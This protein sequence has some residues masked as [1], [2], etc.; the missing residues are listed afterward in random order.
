M[1]D[2]LTKIKQQCSRLEITE[3]HEIQKYLKERHEKLWAAKRAQEAIDHAERIKKLPM[4]T[5][6]I[7]K[8]GQRAGEFGKIHRI[9]RKYVG[10]TLECGDRWKFPVQMVDEHVDDKD[11]QISAKLNRGLQG[12]F[13]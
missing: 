6:V 12:L 2:K 11:L 5:R 10:V 3:I 8:S 4:G 7:I 1:T 9:G 13:G